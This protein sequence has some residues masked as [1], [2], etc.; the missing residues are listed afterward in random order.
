MT[1]GDFPLPYLYLVFKSYYKEYG[2]HSDKWNWP[3]P[4][5]SVEDMSFDFIIETI[6]AEKP[7]VVAFSSYIWNSKLNLEI[8]KAVKAKLPECIT[9]YGGP[10]VPY[11]KSA[12]WLQEHRFVDLICEPKGSGEQF[13][14]A[15]LDQLAE[16]NY[17]PS[18]VPHALYPTEDRSAVIKSKNCMQR[19]AFKW[20]R[21]MFYG[22]EAEITL[23]KHF[24]ESKGGRLSTLWETTCGCP[25]NCSYCDWGG[26]TASRVLKKDD[27]IVYD[28]LRTMEA[29][30]IEYIDLCDANFGINKDRDLGILQ[31]IIDRSKQGW[32]F[33][34][35][36][37]GKTKND[38]ET[39]HKIDLMTLESKIAVKSD[40]HYSVN[41][42]DPVV[43]KA[44]N[45]WSHPTEKH[46]AFIKQVK[47]L[48]YKTRIE[49]IL[50]LPETTLDIFYADYNYIAEADAW[51]SERYVWTLL[52][53]SPAAHPDYVKKYQLKTAPVR[54]SHYSTIKQRADQNYYILND[55]KY[56]AT[57]DIVIE[58]STYSKQDWLQMYFMDNFCRAVE[59]I[60]ITTNLRKVCEKYGIKANTFF[61]T[62][63]KAIEMMGLDRNKDLIE[64]FGGIE[65]SLRG[66]S[67]FAYYQFHG[68]VMGMQTITS[69]FVA[70]NAEEFCKNM[71]S[72]LPN[73]KEITAA[74]AKMLSKLSDISDS[75]EPMNK[76]IDLHSLYVYGPESKKL[77]TFSKTAPPA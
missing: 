71:A 22:N 21:S 58:T 30:N 59:C 32:N 15:L 52:S 77:S 62:C 1:Y 35:G 64:I 4:I 51:L 25:H 73:E 74:V 39:L 57:Y 70:A 47:D 43:S 60:D 56:Q 11:D 34:I 72:L 75:N 27:S 36:L 42:S 5:N 31:Y 24:A 2:Q 9:V 41:A 61:Q 19:A 67:T 28:E 12:T 54:Y 3:L 66:E 23:L 29:L 53:R 63:W 46:V 26:S 38:L 37:N 76:I 40:Y 6:V 45:R 68:Q 20:P 7:K 33:E 16:G 13:M 18:Q 50:G 44:V 48:G 55:P 8:G 10:E 65:K 17:D 69:C 49:Y 14:A